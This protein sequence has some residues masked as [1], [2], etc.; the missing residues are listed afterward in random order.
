MNKAKQKNQIDQNA[1]NAETSDEK[2]KKK[3]KKNDKKQTTTTTKKKV[4]TKNSLTLCD[5]EKKKQIIQ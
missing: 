2:K 3:K 1:V 5:G 4:K